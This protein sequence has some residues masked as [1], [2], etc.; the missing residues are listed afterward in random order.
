MDAP[1]IGPFGPR[2]AAERV[3]RPR[4]RL[5]SGVTQ[6]SSLILGAALGLALPRIEG[7]PAVA[8][9]RTVEVLGAVGVSVLGVTSL[10]FSV[11]FLVVQWA[12]STFTPRLALFRTNP[13]VW[14]VLAFAIG[15][16]AYTVTATLAIGARTTV[17]VWVP[18]VA[19]VLAVLAIVLV[20][21]L[22]LTAF[23]SIQLAHV[24]ADTAEQAHHVIDAFYP[25]PDEEEPG[26]RTQPAR[27]PSILP[28]VRSIVSWDGASTVVEQL[29]LEQLVA[30]ARAAGA[31][32]ILRVPVGATVH[33]GAPVA[34]VR[35]G[36]LETR[37]VT[38]AFVAG[39]ER[40]YHQDPAYPLQVLAD[41]GLRALSPAVND[42]ATAVQVL[43]TVEGLLLRLVTADLDAASVPDAQGSVRVVLC[44]RTWL[45]FLTIA[46]DEILG[47]AVNS[48]M[49][50]SCARDLLRRLA[51][52]ASD[53]RREPVDQ[54]LAWVERQLVDR[55][56][57]F[58]RQPSG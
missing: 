18:T 23:R 25:R 57:P 11:L 34:D 42:P 21:R 12:A 38:R 16:L 33:P 4:R 50:L 49:V 29:D 14:R 3:V 7:G 32:V 15:L 22:Q 30:T 44:L 37:Q 9:T 8:S 40:T 41:I 35:G 54:R 26:I 1:P 39:R 13:L 5:R 10:V 45:E 31:V 47:A 36:R 24:L 55:H 2:Q 56:P 43:E 51:A 27:E 58:M 46:V 48:P 28:L 6:A 20:R 53:D 19:L 17:S 52:V